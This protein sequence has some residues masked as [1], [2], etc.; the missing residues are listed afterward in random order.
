MYR[1]YASKTSVS[2]DKSVGEINKTLQRYGCSEFMHGQKDDKALIQFE[3]E[4]RRIRFV[5]PLPDKLKYSKDRRGKNK[6]VEKAM[7]D[8]EQASRQSY[9]A[10]AL[11]IKAKLEAVQ[12][13][14]TTI[15]AEFLA[16]IVLP[17]G[18][19]FGAWA[20]PQIE[21]A[22]ATNKMPAMMLLESK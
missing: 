8:W 20:S 11:V 19:T 1:R 15:E 22:Y 18:T 7:K 9:R 4:H 5:L 3:L 6:P 12:A 13:E 14:I 16:H 10:L 2:V 21:R 17:D